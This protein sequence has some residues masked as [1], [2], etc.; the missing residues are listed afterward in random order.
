MGQA[1]DKIDMLKGM[2]QQAQRNG[3]VSAQ[4][5]NAFWD[6]VGDRPVAATPAAPVDRAVTISLRVSGSAALPAGAEREIERALA[7]LAGRVGQ[8]VTPGSVRVS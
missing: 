2:V 3:A 4:V 7:G 6:I 8:T 1:R 5:A